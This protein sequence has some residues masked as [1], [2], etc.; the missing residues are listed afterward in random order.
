M[1]IYICVCICVCLCIQK[2][3]DLNV[4]FSF[5]FVCEGTTAPQ[6]GLT[7]TPTTFRIP[8]I[9]VFSGILVIAKVL[10]LLCPKATAPRLHLKVSNLRLRIYIY[11]Y[12]YGLEP[13]A[14]VFRYYR[15]SARELQRL[16]SI[17]KSPIYAS[18]SEALHGSAT[19]AASS[20]TPRFLKQQAARFD[21]NL[22]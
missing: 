17:S 10:P 3:S 5:L 13:S 4:F 7:R 19:I 11:I 15:S 20:A 14:F 6:H 22:R 8:L 18:F 9:Q 12:I 2:T 1:Y 21:H 16:D